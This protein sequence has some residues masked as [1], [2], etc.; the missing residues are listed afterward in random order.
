MPTFL[1]AA[2]APYPQD[3]GANAILP[4]EGRSLFP[5]LRGGTRPPATY[6]WEHEGNRA[7]R[8]GDWKIVSRLPGEW[9]LYDM[10]ADR[11]EAND[12]AQ[13][14]PARVAAM[15]ALYQQWAT[16]VGVPPWR[17]PQTPVGWENPAE[18]YGR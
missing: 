9:E 2:G 18:R 15:S 5:V 1:E 6:G 8:Q 14:M 16:R 10:R 7:L 3:Y 12:L 13:Q 11:L 4:L 17:G